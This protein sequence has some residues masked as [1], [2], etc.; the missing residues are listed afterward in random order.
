MLVLPLESTER[1][2]ESVCQVICQLI[3]GELLETHG[4]CADAVVFTATILTVSL[5]TNALTCVVRLSVV[6]GPVAVAVRSGRA[7]VACT[8]LSGSPDGLWPDWG[9]ANPTIR[10]YCHLRAYNRLVELRG[11][12]G[13]SHRLCVFAARAGELS[14]A[15]GSPETAA[16]GL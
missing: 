13:Y 14:A 2:S 16:A 9:L 5:C 7:C 3:T 15:P 1:A 12:R 4:R 6:D 10:L 8:A 11:Y